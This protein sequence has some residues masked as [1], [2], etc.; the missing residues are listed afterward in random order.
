MITQCVI[1]SVSLGG[2][3]RK[4]EEKEEEKGKKGR[5]SDYT[6][7]NQQWKLGRG[8]KKKGNK[9]RESDYTMSI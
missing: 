5:E 2:G 3:R 9:G 7:C 6:M 1:N 8:K 4:T